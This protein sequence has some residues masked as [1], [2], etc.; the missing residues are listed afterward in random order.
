MFTNGLAL[1]FRPRIPAG[2]ALEGYD[3][4]DFI[5]FTKGSDVSALMNTQEASSMAHGIN[6]KPLVEISWSVICAF[7]SLH[8]LI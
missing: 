2:L 4:V 7:V 3:L 6:S 8:N 5:S 1:I